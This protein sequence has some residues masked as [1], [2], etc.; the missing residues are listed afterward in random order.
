MSSLKGNII[1]N[2]INTISGLIFPII[3]FPYAARVLMPEGIGVVNFQ[4]SIIGYIVLLTSL[5]IPLYAVREIARCRNDLELRDRTTIEVLLLSIILCVF[6]Y[7]IVW[8]LGEYVPRIQEDAKLFYILSLTIIC[9]GIGAQWFYQGIEDFLFITVRGLIIRFLCTIGLFIFVKDKDDLYLYGL[10]VI[11]STVGN[12]IVNCIHLRKYVKLVRVKWNQLNIVRHIKPA[13]Q[14]FMLNVIISVYIQLNTVMLGFMTDDRAVGLFTSGT[15]LTHLIIVVLTSLGTAMLPR[16]S[17]LISEGKYDDFNAVIT[18]S[19]HLLM[20][21]AIPLTVGT[22]LLA[23]PLVYCF[24]G[25]E[26]SG[27]VPVV[28]YTAPTIILI[29]MTQVIGIQ[30]LYPYGKENLVIISTLVAAVVNVFLNIFLIPFFAEVGAAISTLVSEFSVLIVQ[31]RLGRTF[32]PFRYWD[33]QISIYLFASFLMSIGI[34][35]CLV[36]P[37]AWWQMFAGAA[38]GALI[39]LSVLYSRKDEI[40]N[41][42]FVIL[43]RR[44]NR[45]CRKE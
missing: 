15:K 43:Q 11:G 1:L 25:G 23:R 12:N 33:K 22:I 41:E 7:I 32:I 16:C 44:R 17:N 20:F 29:G 2:Y 36:F 4:N 40:I 24:C 37:N 34:L 3:T 27:S 38:V 18:K 8:L 10:Y 14:I 42:F 28:L 30:I 35:M 19:Y 26:F 45:S 39:Y 6:G 5:G 31:V 9:T 21:S 13:F